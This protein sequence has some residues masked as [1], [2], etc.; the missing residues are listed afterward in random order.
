MVGQGCFRCHPTVAGEM[1]LLLIKENDSDGDEK[2][3]QYETIAKS[4]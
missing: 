2:A 1:Q 4:L 3:D